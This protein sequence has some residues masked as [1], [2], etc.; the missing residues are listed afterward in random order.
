MASTAS[1]A[2]PLSLRSNGGVFV[3]VCSTILGVLRLPTENRMPECK[4]KMKK[5]KAKEIKRNKC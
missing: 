2:I 1:A 4:S 3:M 5:A